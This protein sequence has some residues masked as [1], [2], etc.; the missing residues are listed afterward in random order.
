MIKM[1]EH[2]ALEKPIV[3]FDLSE[4]RYAA[5][6]AAL[7]FDSTMRSSSPERWLSSWTTPRADRLWVCLGVGGLRLS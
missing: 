6:A 3:V 5:Q 4:H 2:I 7:T 1:L